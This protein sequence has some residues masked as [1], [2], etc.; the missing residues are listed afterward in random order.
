MKKIAIS[1]GLDKK[2]FYE[3]EDFAKLESQDKSKFSKKLINKSLR[4]YKIKYA[5]FLYA[6]KLLSLG[7]ASEF[8]GLNILNFINTL[9][10]YKIN[11]NYSEE[12]L[13][14]DL[15]ILEEAEKIK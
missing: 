10:K 13:E 7:K 6:K 15:K 4:E 5:L 12:N 8:S 3:S 9:K 11:L 2:Y 14:N 1:K